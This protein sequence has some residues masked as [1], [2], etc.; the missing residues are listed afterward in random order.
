MQFGGHCTEAVWRRQP[1]KA[2]LYDRLLLAH[3][4][5]RVD[6][7][8]RGAGETALGIRHSRTASAIEW[9]PQ[10]DTCVFQLATNNEM[11]ER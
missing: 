8:D 3:L 2:L 7:E 1:A 6:A 9:S 10:P 4:L 5:A 11:G